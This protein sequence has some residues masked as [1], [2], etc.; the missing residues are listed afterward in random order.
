MNTPLQMPF[1]MTQQPMSVAQMQGGRSP[2]LTGQNISAFSDNVTSSGGLM[3]QFFYHRQ[4]L[5]GRTA[6]TPG[7]PKFETRLA[8][9][10]KPR[11]DMLTLAVHN[12]TEEDAQRE[13][14]VE[15][16]QFKHYMDTPTRGTPLHELPNA[17][18]SMIAIL[19]LGGIRSIE[20]LV[21][22]PTDVCQNMGMDAFEAQKLAK[23]WIQ[24]KRG[25]ADDINLAERLAALEADKTAKDAEL[26]RLRQENAV[27]AQTIEALKSIGFGAAANPAQ[28][29]AQAMGP[30]VVPAGDPSNFGSSLPQRPAGEDGDSGNGS[31]IF[32]ITELIQG[33]ENMPDPLAE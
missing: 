11:G 1:G 10:K 7:A 32:T 24:R 31:D 21:N 33:T 15:W 29:P 22:V 6:R 14:P 16:Q 19:V 20:D 26:T 3:V 18:Q 2:D 8:V 30:D 28:P 5:G 9:A 23:I 4:P 17:T 25:A 13:F 12:I 27:A